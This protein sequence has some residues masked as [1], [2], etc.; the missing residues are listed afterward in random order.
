MSTADNHNA[1]AP[2]RTLQQVGS[3]S[4]EE[5]QSPG[6]LPTAS[7]PI[8]NSLAT[9]WQT[10][11]LPPALLA[12]SS[13][14]LVS[15]NANFPQIE[16]FQISGELGRGGMGVVYRVTKTGS[17]RAC[18]L[19]M[20]LGGAYAGQEEFERFM[21]EGEALE[22]LQHPHIVQIFE[23]GISNG[24]HYFLL[25][26]VDGGNL[27]NRMKSQP[28]SYREAVHLVEKLALAVQHAHEH[29]VVH[30]DLKPVNILL[31]KSGEPKITDFGLAK[32]DEVGFTATK[33]VLGTPSYM[34]PEQASGSS[35]LA[36][37]LAD[38]FALGVILYEML[39][40]HPPFEGKTI[41][42][43]LQKVIH[44][45]PPRLRVQTVMNASDL[46]AVVLKCLEKSPKNRYLSAGKLAED[47][48]HWLEGEETVAR[49]IPLS[50]RLWRG[51]RRRLGWRNIFIGMVGLILV[52]S[53][54]YLTSQEVPSTIINR[55]PN[56]NPESEAFLQQV[57]DEVLRD[58]S[59]IRSREPEILRV[60]HPSTTVEKTV[61]RQ[62]RSAFELISDRRVWDLRLWK[63]VPIEMRDQPISA[64]VL[65]DRQRM[66]KVQ[67][68][69]EYRTE[70]RTTGLA[71]FLESLSHPRSFRIIAEEEKGFV[72]G[73]EMKA[74]QIVID[75]KDIPVDEEFEIRNRTTYWNNLQDDTD[76]WL[77]IIGYD[78]SFKVSMLFVF[79]DDRP[80]KD[81]ELLVAPMGKSKQ[82][83]VPYVGRKTLI[84]GPK[85]DYL[86]WDILEPKANHVYMVKWKW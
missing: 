27:A 45:P 49:P 15:A 18:A 82:V 3:P 32:G 68:I 2:D 29:H 75:I 6:P 14:N 72:G 76:R 53:I 24:N 28:Y 44:D 1:P 16:G 23:R 79:P 7:A 41:N 67:P 9:L 38:V 34:S 40:G 69:D 26:F 63:P 17:S 57:R 30:R 5:S 50:T 84:A 48:R 81:Y 51:I 39:S 80:M 19:K 71:T 37:P 73:D 25:E 55:L 83:P 52:G 64:I 33:A 58:V 36:G 43:I 11:D 60:P 59:K 74:R 66:K 54:I 10:G 77:G 86:Y 31:T 13:S 8:L 56:P 85:G 21:K 42:E 78:G 4:V 35:N 47:L 70:A 46:E 22:K 62:D 61:I 65:T 20:I 12:Q